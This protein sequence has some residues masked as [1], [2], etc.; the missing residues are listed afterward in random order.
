MLS[1]SSIVHLYL[2]CL[3]TEE[4]YT[5]LKGGVNQLPF[6]ATTKSGQHRLALFAHSKQLIACET[7]E[8][9]DISRFLEKHS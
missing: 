2:D 3:S 1:G 7:V 9:V 4:I 6:L 5:H 8:K